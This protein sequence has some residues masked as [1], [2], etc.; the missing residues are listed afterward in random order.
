M[1][2]EICKRFIQQIIA[3]RLRFN[4]VKIDNAER[5]IKNNSYF[6]S[7]YS[8]E[9]L[10]NRAIFRQIVLQFDR[11]IIAF[12]VIF[13]N[14]K[15]RSSFDSDN[16]SSISESL[17]FR[18]QR[19]RFFSSMISVFSS[20]FSIEST[21]QR[22]SRRFSSF[23][24][25]VSRTN[26]M[27]TINIEIFDNI[28]Q[29]ANNNQSIIKQSIN[30]TD[31]T[32]TNTNIIM[33]ENYNNIDFNQLQWNVFQILMQKNNIF[34][35]FDSFDSL[36]FQDTSTSKNVDNNH[37][38]KWNVDEIDFFDFM[39][40]DKSIVIENFIVHI[41]KNIYFRDV[42]N[43]IDRVKN[44]TNVKNV[45]LIRHNFYTCF[46]DTIL[47]WYIIVFIENQKKLI[48]LN[49]DVKKWI[50]TL[51]KRFKESEF[52][53]MIVIKQKRYIMKNVRRKKKSLKYVHIIIKIVKF[54]IMNIYFQLWLIYHDL[55]TKF[56]RDVRKSNEHIDLNV[57]LHEMKK[58]KKIW[59]NLNVK[60][61]REYNYAAFN[62]FVNVFRFVD[63]QN[64]YNNRS[65]VNNEKNLSQENYSNDFDYEYSY[66]DNQQQQQ[67]RQTQFF[68]IY[69]FNNFFY[70]NRAY[71]QNQS[72]FRFQQQRSSSSIEIDQQYERSFS[73]QKQQS[74][75]Q[76]D[77]MSLI[78]LFRSKNAFDF[79][80][81]SS[82]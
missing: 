32:F 21:Q 10:F 19:F 20:I 56:R 4:D 38:N 1:F 59:W 40:D 30:F 36:N 81:K 77:F 51:H 78:I 65:D 73:Q 3:N 47:I 71:S 28:D 79:Q 33:I 27:S 18:N 5:Q 29:F 55:N 74:Y 52:V 2:I 67:S 31:F 23:D 57:F 41:D 35:S 64:S 25:F 62:R 46:R 69:Q 80:F 15:F 66:V 70:Q 11:N 61:N 17:V 13:E 16:S 49:N 44:M 63:Q 22:K 37:N 45:E 76:T 48:K 42:T 58:I 12:R 24:F 53:I 68:I 39:Y 8:A 75:R 43:F 14:F 6:L 34:D 82:Q 50:R 7:S 60:H 26:S 9:W 54:T 72:N